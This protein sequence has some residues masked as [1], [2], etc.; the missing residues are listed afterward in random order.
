[1]DGSADQ[2]PDDIIRLILAYQLID[3]CMFVDG[4]EF[5]QKNLDKHGNKSRYGP[6]GMHLSLI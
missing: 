5:E 2:H 1:M 6:R 3:T 4:L